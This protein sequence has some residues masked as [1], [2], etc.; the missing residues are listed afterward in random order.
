MCSREEEPLVLQQFLRFGETRP[1]TQGLI[2]QELSEKNNEEQRAR[3]QVRIN[4][5]IQK[6]QKTNCFYF[7]IHKLDFK[8]IL[9]RHFQSE[10]KKLIERNS[11]AS[12]MAA[13]AAA[14]AAAIHGGNP[15]AAAL[16]LAAATNHQ[17]GGSTGSHGL[18]P[19]LIKGEKGAPGDVSPARSH[20][21]RASP[22][23]ER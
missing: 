23:H 3:A 11:H 14:A 20:H 5:L 16:A 21:S 4:L 8:L 10:I 19:P 6:V 2:L 17:N 18:P 7:K 13:A 9:F 22:M 15:N 1:V 12:Q